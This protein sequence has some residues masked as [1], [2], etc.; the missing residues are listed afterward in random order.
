MQNWSL[1]ALLSAQLNDI[2]L[3]EALKLIQLRATSR[4]LADYDNFKFAELYQFRKIFFQ[5]VDDTIIGSEPF[6]GEMLTLCKVRVALSDNIYQILTNYYNNAYELQ[7]VTI[8]E[9]I[10]ISSRDSIVMP[11]MVDQFGH[12]WI[13]TEVF[14]SAMAPRYLK[15]ANV[16]AKFIQNNEATDLFPGRVQYYFEHTIRILGE[17]KTHRLAFI[18]W[19]KL[20]PNQKI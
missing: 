18:K 19:Y 13:S 11:N 1:D 20:A 17:L 16:L 5:E 2:K 6:P 15:N 3:I 14:G 4:S 9:S 10:S 7:F 8:A 12:V